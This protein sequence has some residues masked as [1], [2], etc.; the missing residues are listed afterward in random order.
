MAPEEV[1]RTLA[2][3]CEVVPASI[4][5]GAGMRRHVRSGHHAA[6]SF[7]SFMRLFGDPLAFLGTLELLEMMPHMA[8]VVL[9]QP[10]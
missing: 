7:V 10:L 3:S 4:L 9:H 5:D 1:R 6:E 8:D 2:I